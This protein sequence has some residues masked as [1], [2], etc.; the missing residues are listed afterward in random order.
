MGTMAAP[1]RYQYDYE[2]DSRYGTNGVGVGD[3]TGHYNREQRPQY[4]PLY[5]DHA[6]ARHYEDPAPFPPQLPQPHQANVSRRIPFA[7]T[8]GHGNRDLS[9]LPPLPASPRWDSFSSHASQQYPSSPSSARFPSYSHDYQPPDHSYSRQGHHPPVSYD[10]SSLMHER[11]NSPFRP[12]ASKSSL[13]DMRSY[14]PSP[15]ENFSRPR[16]K[17]LRQ[18]IPEHSQPQGQTANFPASDSYY[19]SLPSPTHSA[20]WQR[21]RGP[22]ISSWKSSSSNFTPNY[23]PTPGDVSDPRYPR[24]RN[25]TG[26]PHLPTGRPPFGNRVDSSASA[27]AFAGGAPPWLGGDELRS[28]FRS[29]YSASSGPVTTFTERSSVLTKDTSIG[30]VDAHPDEPSL[31]DVMGM[32]EN[33]FDDGD[34]DDHRDGDKHNSSR[35]TTPASDV[36]ELRQPFGMFS[37]QHED[38]DRQRPPTSGLDAE[39]R[40]SKMIFTSFEFISSVSHIAEKH[41]PTAEDED[42]YD[43]DGKAEEKR[44]S[45]KSLDSDPSLKA[46][47]S[48]DNVR[49]EPSRSFNSPSP[50]PSPSPPLPAPSASLSPSPA[51]QPAVFEDPGCRDRYGFKKENQ[52]IT[53]AQYDAWDKGYTTYLARRRKKWLAYLKDNSLI[54]ENPTR[55]PPQ[56][57]KTRRFVRKG[58]PPD[59]RGAAWFYYAGGPK[60]LAKHA[61]LYGKLLDRSASKVDSDAIERDLHRT[62]PD[63]IKFKPPGSKVPE[64][65]GSGRESQS[66][67]TRSASTSGS[68]ELRIPEDEPPII[69]ALRRVLHAFAIYNPQIG[70]CQS[71]NFLAGMLLLFVETEEHCFW[72]LNVIT[73]IYLP[74]THETTLEGSKIDLGVLMTELRDTM[75]NVWDKVGGELEAEPTG[76]PQ[77]SKSLRKPRGKSRRGKGAPSLSTE[78]LPPI[79]LCMTAWFMSCFIGTFPT[80]TTLR[81]WDVFFLEGSKTLFRVALSIFKLGES[82]IKAVKDPMEMFGVVQS[83]PRRLLDANEM[84]EMCFKRRNGF[85]HL[86]QGLIDDRRQE[87]RDLIR[88]DLEEQKL[89]RAATSIT[90]TDEAGGK[91]HR[92]GTLFGRKKRSDS[93]LKPTEV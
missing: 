84:M 63:N 10:G 28:S 88:R 60:I 45:G 71:L 19:D 83:I 57:D 61:G 22:S 35:P 36:P 17:S 48:V 82:E 70:Y 3:G 53:R 20:P 93:K 62:F 24:M 30:S 85:G 25:V 66:T 50:S 13:G 89:G 79:T 34:D 38:E 37:S 86:T 56:N 16:T 73:T 26:P 46:D 92:K 78:R 44:D 64:A 41:N 55:F 51:P 42:D 8:P 54:T 18:P 31:E 74:G 87:R 90:A 4:S 91:V 47:T 7:L 1:Y 27:P 49:T 23:P 9:Q 59:W 29:Q 5:G 77:T 52:Y 69:S 65:A 6:Q 58:I 12:L 43:D 75:P 32:Y 72:L 15:I 76:R 67:L 68:F 14:D 81:V 40:Q 80:E 21:P 2:P 39:I 11:N 33:G